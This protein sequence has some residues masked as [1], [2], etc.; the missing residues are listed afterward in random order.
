[1]GARSVAL[2]H[3]GVLGKEHDLR[4][5][6]GSV[7]RVEDVR[8]SALT[9]AKREKAEATNPVASSES[10]GESDRRRV[11]QGCSPGSCRDN[12]TGKQHRSDR[13]RSGGE[14]LGRADG[15]RGVSVRDER[16]E[17]HDRGEA[18]S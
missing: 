11:E 7:L 2:E 14:L 10:V 16:E 4:D 13:A 9:S 1:V 6:A 18:E 12:S 5:R 17:D 15:E 3:D 8:R